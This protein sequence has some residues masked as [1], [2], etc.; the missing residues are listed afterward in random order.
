MEGAG[1]IGAVVAGP[2]GES[3]PRQGGGVRLAASGHCENVDRPPAGLGLQLPE[4]AVQL[5]LI[6]PATGAYEND[7]LDAPGI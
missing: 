6:G 4:Q 7:R 3:Y 1:G 5:R 2:G